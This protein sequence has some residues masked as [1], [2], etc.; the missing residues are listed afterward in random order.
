LA[1]AALCSCKYKII[2][3]DI[4]VTHP[5][6]ATTSIAATMLPAVRKYKKLSNSKYNDA[7]L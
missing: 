5:P 3:K 2:T 7:I 6:A 1:Y 4:I